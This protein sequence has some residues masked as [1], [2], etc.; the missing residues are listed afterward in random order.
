MCH[1]LSL[2]NTKLRDIL[3]LKKADTQYGEISTR[4]YSLNSYGVSLD[5][6]KKQPDITQTHYNLATLYYY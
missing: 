6:I 1:S 5:N 4:I 3:F 2:V